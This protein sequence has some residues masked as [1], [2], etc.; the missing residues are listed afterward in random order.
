MMQKLT[1]IARFALAAAILTFV[2]AMSAADKKDLDAK[3]LAAL[4][5]SA[6]SAED[7]R[8]LGQLYQQRAVMLDE[9]AER[10]DRLEQRYASAPKS[11]IAKR[12]HG[13]NTPKRQAELAA[14]ARQDAEDARR[15]AETHLAQADSVSTDVD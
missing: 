9:K 11:L 6:D 4:A 1:Q 5:E 14:K 2:P 7:F 10:H 12:G 13:W 15:M 8:E 3:R